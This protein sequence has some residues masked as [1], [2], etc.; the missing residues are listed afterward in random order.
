[1][2]GKL[3]KAEW[4]ASRRVVGILCLAVLIAALVGLLIYF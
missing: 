1:M 4:R 2:F 3:M